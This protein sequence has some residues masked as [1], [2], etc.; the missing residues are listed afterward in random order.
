MQ[1]R[2]RTGTIASHPKIEPKS[3]Q[4]SAQT[5][6]YRQATWFRRNR[7]LAAAKTL[8]K[9]T[10]LDTICPYAYRNTAKTPKIGLNLDQNTAETV[11]SRLTTPF[12]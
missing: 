2:Y 3:K 6:W 11:T 1:T 5:R 7:F 8:G 4:L 10:A 12:L 9:P